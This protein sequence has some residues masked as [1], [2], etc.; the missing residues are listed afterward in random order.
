MTQSVSAAP[1]RKKPI[2]RAQVILHMVFIII[3]ASY[4]LPL[5]LTVAI[6]FSTQVDIINYGYSLI[7]RTWTGE[8][9]RLIFKNPTQ[10]IDSY[11][12]TAAF[13]FVGMA[14][15]LIVQS[16]CA[17]AISRQNCSFRKIVTYL[18]FFTMLFSGGLVPSYVVNSKYLGL[19][20]SF[21]IY[22]LPTLVSAWNIFV[23][24]TNFK[25]LPEGLIEAAKIDGASEIRICYQIVMPLSVPV[26]ATLAFTYFVGQ[27]NSWTTCMIY[28]TDPK[29]F[30]LQYLLQ[31]ILSEVEYLKQMVAEGMFSE[32]QLD[33]STDS[34][35]YAMAMVAA[36]P[37]LVLF[38]LFQ[39]YFVKGM[40]I[41]SIKG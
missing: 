13:S 14:L 35:T 23:M 34:L 1:R 25:Q 39:K 5:A 38:P 16:S 19:K 40:T 22:V 26:L 10:I 30:S 31:K 11:A 6:S 36:G 27:W 2:R 41:G 17:Y 9:Y 15:M 3:C 29:M 8:S 24:R 12:V 33:I 4:I 37:V 21:W 28:I 7:P 32:A 18:L 20:N